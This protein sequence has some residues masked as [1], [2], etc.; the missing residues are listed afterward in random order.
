MLNLLGIKKLNVFKK[1][2]V[3]IIP[4]GSELT[5]NIDDVIQYGKVLNTN[6]QIISSLIEAAGEFQLI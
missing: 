6:S 3:A 4:T 2:R 5:N 1:P